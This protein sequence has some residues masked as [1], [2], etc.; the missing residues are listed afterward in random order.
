[1]DQTSGEAV[2]PELSQGLWGG[3][4]PILDSCGGTIPGL[5]VPC[6]TGQQ[7]ASRLSC[8]STPWSKAVWMPDLPKVSLD[9]ETRRKSRSNRYRPS[10]WR[11]RARLCSGRIPLAVRASNNL[12]L[13][14][15][16]IQ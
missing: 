8:A 5:E 13:E 6:E 4:A 15:S 7:H 11:S 3:G 9:T 2:L 14:L 10:G 12:T 1:M 16:L